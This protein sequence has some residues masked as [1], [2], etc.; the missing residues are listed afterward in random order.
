MTEREYRALD[1]DSYSSI[2][3]FVEDRKKYYRKFI[4]K[5][6][7]KEEDTPETIF[8]SLVDCLLLTPEEYEARYVLSVSQVPTGQYGKFVNA[9]WEITQVNMNPANGMI[10]QSLDSMMEEAYNKVKFDRDGNIVDFKRDD[11]ATV[12]RKF[13]GSD[14]EGHYR[15]LRESYGKK[16]IELSDL[17]KAQ[18]VVQE[19][20]ANNVTKEVINITDNERFTVHSQYPII[21]KFDRVI[22]N[23]TEE[24]YPLK[25]L[26]DKLIIDHQKRMIYI[27]DLKTAWDNEY[28]FQYNYYK[29]KYYIQQ[30]VYFYLVVEWKKLQKGLED[31]AVNF[32]RFLVAESSNYKN[33]LIYTT[34]YENFNQG[35]K[36]FI[37]RGR[38]HPGIIKAIQ[39]IMWHKEKGVWNI[40]SDNYATNGVV[41]IKPFENED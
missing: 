41:K 1:I 36:G 9:L 40:S 39:D 12:K 11:F 35:M 24:D 3:T 10:T 28:Q 30:A 23:A 13:L 2:K 18:A 26:V 6:V 38:Y 19:L 37:L 17:E 5:E 21:G 4:L 16:V 32:P 31:Y 20:K 34:N 14:L 7:I 8:G 33:P 22:L 15:Q 29:Y 27:Y 25:C